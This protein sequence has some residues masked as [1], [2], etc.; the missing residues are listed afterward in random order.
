M[1]IKKRTEKI[2][3]WSIAWA[4]FLFI[5]L[6]LTGGKSLGVTADEIWQNASLYTG[7]LNLDSRHYDNSTG[8]ILKEWGGS[9][10]AQDSEGRGISKT[11]LL[12]WKPGVLT[13][14]YADIL[15]RQKQS[16]DKEVYGRLLLS[17][18]ADVAYAD[19]NYR[20][21][22]KTGEKEAEFYKDLPEG[23][24]ALP[25]VK[26][27][28]KPY[29]P[30]TNPL[31]RSQI[32]WRTASGWVKLYIYPR[33]EAEAR[34]ELAVPHSALNKLELDES[35][36]NSDGVLY[37]DLKD[38]ASELIT[39]DGI[40]VRKEGLL[41]WSTGIVRAN[42]ADTLARQKSYDASDVSVYG[43]IKLKMPG[44]S[45]LLIIKKGDEDAYFSPVADGIIAVPLLADIY[46]PYD[47]VSNPLVKTTVAWKD[48]NGL[49][50]KF[51]LVPLLQTEQILQGAAL[52]TK[53]PA[54][55]PVLYNE[56]GELYADV[57]NKSGVLQAK[58][59]K[60]ILTRDNV[61]S[62]SGG[63]LAVNYAETL[64]GQKTEKGNGYLGL[65]Y[66]E[67]IAPSGDTPRLVI[68]VEGQEARFYEE[69]G[70]IL[71]L[72]LLKKPGLS[73][74]PQSNPLLEVQLAWRT[75]GGWQKIT[76]KPQRES[77]K[78]L[79]KSQHP[80]AADTSIWFDEKSL[81]PA[82]INGKERYFVEA[83]F[84]DDD[85]T[86]QRGNNFLSLLRQCEVVVAGGSSGSMVDEELLDYAESLEGEKKEAFINQYLFIRDTAR[87]QVSLR[88]PIKKL[89][90]Q[91]RYEVR[92]TSGLVFYE[93]GEGNDFI[94]WTFTT[95]A[96][97]QITDIYVGSIGEDYDASY[98]LIIRGDF[99]YRSGITVKFN[100]IEASRVEVAVD[101]QGKPYLK[102]YL[103]EGSRRLPPGVYDIKVINNSNENYKAVLAGRLSVV[104]RG[105]EKLPGE[106][107]WKREAASYGEVIES[108][109]RREA[110]LYLKPSWQDRSY[111]FL[112]LEEIMPGNFSLRKIMFK[113][114]RWPVI[115][116]LTVR[117]REGE[118]VFRNIR[119]NGQAEDT[120]ITLGRINPAAISAVGYQLPHYRIRSHLI[121]V[122]AENAAFTGI[123]TKIFFPAE[124][125]EVFK[126]VRY[127]EDYRRFYDIP[128]RI[129]YLNG[130]AVFTTVKPGIFVL[131]EP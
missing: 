10:P 15:G 11:A 61:L 63:F 87:K 32:A 49:W 31:Q 82:T 37:A 30:L 50:N 7:Q 104:P 110:V 6:G 12:S 64:A 77:R 2:I 121:A 88:L 68:K 90:T 79:L 105:K 128:A 3:S 54:L 5:I 53:S 23:K 92:I 57:V 103:S 126:V 34:L 112:D 86:L 72:P 96:V 48:E 28:E 33:S 130:E 80:W 70:N 45:G 38:P 1:Q 100:D 95:M 27:T 83:V 85:G 65:S 24:F 125:G 67:N 116:E 93:N 59:G 94:S 78:P 117:S 97:P 42:Y 18:P 20:F 84:V 120:V 14:N 101:S 107:E 40:K 4:C 108:P 89:L 44:Y 46:K 115:R 16:T 119:V 66:P 62:W 127:D 35:Y 55:A 91:S 98:P 56:K 39:P 69:E 114:Y 19:G 8:Y 43:V 60:T 25:L 21:V 9:E 129:D 75:E 29:D 99:F 22:V 123:E 102:V 109:D 111:I 81:Y 73:Y 124:K 51:T 113:G 41:S 74:H 17:L 106:G 58:D 52:A 76:I 131:I 26:D 36:Y 122:K 118:V 71:W 47:G 13:V